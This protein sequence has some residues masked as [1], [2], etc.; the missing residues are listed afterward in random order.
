[1]RLRC[2]LT[3][4]EVHRDSNIIG[5]GRERLPLPVTTDYT[6]I[7]ARFTDQ[8]AAEKLANFMT[9]AGIQCDIVDSW[10]AVSCET[11]GVRVLRNQ[12]PDLR[13][14]LELTPVAKRLTPTAAQV[15][16]GQLARENIACYVGGWHSFGYL[17]GSSLTLDSMTTLKETKEAGDM[18]AVPASLF[19]KAIRILNQPPISETELTKLA[20]GTAPDPK[21]PL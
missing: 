10:D 9:S 12:I 3:L 16:A 1:M 21:D 5:G 6:D 13:R 4:V 15:M 20:L 14:V 11:H 17:W 18:I 19:K 8:L 2:A 7:I